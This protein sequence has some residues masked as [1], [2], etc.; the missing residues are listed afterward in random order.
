LIM[1]QYYCVLKANVA[2]LW[3]DYDYFVVPVSRDYF[4]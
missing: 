1:S 4:V 3:H 2:H